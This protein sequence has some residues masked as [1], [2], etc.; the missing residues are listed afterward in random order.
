[1]MFKKVTYGAKGNVYQGIEIFELAGSLYYELLKLERKKGEL[2]LIGA[3]TFNSLKELALQIDQKKPLLLHIYTTKVLNKQLYGDMP[4]LPEHWVNQ[5]FP[6]LNLEQFYYQIL[7]DPKVGMVSITKKSAIDEHLSKLKEI[8][9]VPSGISIGISGLSHC[10]SFLAHPIQGSNFIIDNK[11]S[12]QMELSQHHP[13][14]VMEINIQGLQLPSTHLLVFSQILGHIQGSVPYSNLREVN[15]EMN[16]H[17][18]NQ[19]LYQKGLQWGLSIMLG[20]LLVNFLLFSHY[21]TKTMASEE[22]KDPEQQAR[23]AQKLQERIYTKEN[24]IKALLGSSRTRTT[25]YMD[26]IGE[27]LPESILLDVLVYQPLTRPVQPDKTIRTAGNQISISGQTND[28]VAF[29]KWTAQLESMEWVRNLEIE[30]YEYS[31]NTV[32][33][34]SIKIQCDATGQTK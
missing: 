24:K 21:R 11:D 32:D 6:N 15:T 10:L 17:F 9:I 14:L 4:K 8:G 19:R 28:K 2:I 12:R 7:D 5:A 16:N 34:F 13:G 30:R 33:N 29:A 26:R 22:P 27:G 31:S 3:L 23:M 1:M 20:I 18:H 25:Y